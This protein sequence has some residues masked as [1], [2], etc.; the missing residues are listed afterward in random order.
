MNV[1]EYERKIKEAY[2]DCAKSFLQYTNNYDL[3][4]WCD[5]NAL[6][7]DKY[8]GEERKFLSEIQIAFSEVIK[9]IDRD[10]KGKNAI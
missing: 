2:N 1:R 8:T 4:E 5:R 3:D 7:L 6:L 9:K 10:I